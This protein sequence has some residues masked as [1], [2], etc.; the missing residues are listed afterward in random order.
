MNTPGEWRFQEMFFLFA[1]LLTW[2][3]W[4]PAALLPAGEPALVRMFLHYLG[5]VMPLATAL[6]IVYT[7]HTQQEQRDYWWRALDFSRIGARWYVVVLL[8]APAL[9]GLSALADALLGGTG[10]QMDAAADFIHLPL[11]FIPFALFLLLF[12]P[13]PEELAWRGY[14]LDRLQV[15]WNALSSSLLLG[16]FWMVWHLPLFFIEGSYQ[17]SLG[18]WTPAFWLYQFDKLPQTIL[19]TWFYNNNQRSTLVAIL[20]HWM[21]NLTG[22]LFTISLR[23]EALYVGLW[24]LVASLGVWGPLGLARRPASA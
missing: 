12:G 15:R 1:L 16:L 13:I 8:L 10:A 17:H 23:A 20:F 3:F 6:A 24:W 14:A 21:V 19:M 5:G 2:L 11:S 4:I 22:E 9:T 18:V 7:R